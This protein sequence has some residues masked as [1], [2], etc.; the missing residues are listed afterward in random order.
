MDSPKCGS[1]HRNTASTVEGCSYSFLCV[2]SGRPSRYS[3]AWEDDD[4]D[5]LADV[6]G[7]SAYY[8]IIMVVLGD[9]EQRRARGQKRVGRADDRVKSKSNS[10]SFGVSHK[11]KLHDAPRAES[12]DGVG[13]APPLFLSTGRLP[14]G[15]QPLH[16]SNQPTNQPFDNRPTR[17]HAC[18]QVCAIR[19]LASTF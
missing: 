3:S 6:D 7:G 4:T 9:V 10:Q 5:I 12:I 2:C 13:G 19:T 11:V 8:R 1:M 17:N 16:S 15:I 14:S 18:T